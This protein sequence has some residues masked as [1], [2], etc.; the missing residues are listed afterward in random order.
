MHN[1]FQPDFETVGKYATDLFT[2]RAIKLINT[3]DYK[4]PLFLL[5][6]HLA[7]H[8]GKLDEETN[9]TVLEEKSAYKMNRRFGYIPDVKRRRYAGN[10]T[11]YVCH[12]FNLKS[13]SIS[14]I[15]NS[16]DES[17]GEIVNALS[18]RG[19]LRNTMILFM[20]DNGGQTF[21]MHENFASN[22][23]LRGVSFS[24]ISFITIYGRCYSWD[25]FLL[26][27]IYAF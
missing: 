22:W 9:N 18:T 19:V 23:P 15:V 13:R 4:Q 8:T 27:E 1:N 3:H 25:A 2:D 7:P 5:V 6:S 17:I 14:D 11:R 12:S 10:S 16:V 26:A 21:G 20:S 24:F